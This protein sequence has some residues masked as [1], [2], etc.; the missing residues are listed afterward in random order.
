[1]AADGGAVPGSPTKEA[2][3]T[4]IVQERG[5]TDG[6]TKYIFSVEAPC[7]L[8]NDDVPGDRNTI[9]YADRLEIQGAISRPGLRIALYAREIVGVGA[10]AGIDVSGRSAA[11]TPDA[12]PPGAPGST[13]QNG[14]RQGEGIT[15]ASDGGQA[16][17]GGDGQAGGSGTAAGSITVVAYRLSGSALH[18]RANGG[19][20][21]NGQAGGAGGRG[22]S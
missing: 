20:G 22:Q 4:R 7:R 15:G 1:M 8:T 3:A 13:G 10:D 16:Q 21:A 17:N 9:V 6:T 5:G 19:S 12:L 11:D 18:F 14:Q 2:L